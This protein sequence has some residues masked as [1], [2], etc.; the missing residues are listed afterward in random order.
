[1]SEL[2]YYMHVLYCIAINFLLQS[3]VLFAY[4]G[5]SG[6]SIVFYG[7]FVIFIAVGEGGNGATGVFRAV[8]G[9]AAMT[10]FSAMLWWIAGS[11]G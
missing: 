1:M 8:L 3:L 2:A 9:I 4:P 10:L 6:L 5:A 11:G 7:A